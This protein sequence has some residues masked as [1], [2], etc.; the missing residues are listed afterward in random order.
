MAAPL[1][2]E[3][4]ETVK[5]FNRWSFEDVQ[6]PSII[7]SYHQ[8]MLWRKEKK[9]IRCRY[10][11]I[12][13]SHYWMPNGCCLI[14][15][16]KYWIPESSFPRCAAL[17][18]LIYVESPSLF[19]RIRR[20][21]Q[22]KSCFYFLF[23]YPCFQSVPLDHEC[24]IWLSMSRFNSF[25]IREWAAQKLFSVMLSE[26]ESIWIQYFLVSLR[27]SYVSLVSN[28]KI[29]LLQASAFSS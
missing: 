10:L 24:A 19:G 7:P 21:R 1:V 9:R 5:L 22:S 28:C 14:F 23:A 12:V 2:E 27:W 17:L 25:L 26:K 20:W 18:L 8:C 15:S 6:V 11:T 4:A 29:A 3:E 16:V 13:S